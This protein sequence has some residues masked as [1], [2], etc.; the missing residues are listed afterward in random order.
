VT[1]VGGSLSQFNESAFEQSVKTFLVQQVGISNAATWTQT[2]VNTTEYPVV[3]AV[4]R[5]TSNVIA[6]AIAESFSQN[7]ATATTQLAAAGVTTTTCRDCFVAR[8]YIYVLPPVSH[9]SRG[10]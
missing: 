2:A 6:T 10:K 1:T 3:R 8:H 9:H 7:Q 5:S 4:A